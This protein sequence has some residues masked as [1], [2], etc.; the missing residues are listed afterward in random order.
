MDPLRAA[1]GLRLETAVNQYTLSLRSP[2][3]RACC[4]AASGRHT[5]LP[6]L[7]RSSRSCM[8]LIRSR[9][10]SFWVWYAANAP[11]GAFAASA[12]DKSFDLQLFATCAPS[13]GDVV[14]IRARRSCTRDENA[15]QDLE[16]GTR[17]SP[18]TV[19][20]IKRRPRH[21]RGRS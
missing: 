18:Y 20:S 3:W 12:I 10:V 11:A 21:R 15:R 9:S 14:S 7:V 17:T 6:G 2:D 16:Y 4:V 5:M 1:Q 13:G 8:L 19:Q